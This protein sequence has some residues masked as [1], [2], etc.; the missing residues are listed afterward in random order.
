MASATATASSGRRRPKPRSGATRLERVG[1]PTAALPARRAD[2]RPEPPRPA[3]SGDRRPGAERK[4]ARPDPGADRRAHH[5]GPADQLRGRQ[6]GLAAASRS[7]PW[8]WGP[9]ARSCASWRCR[10]RSAPA[11]SPPTALVIAD[12]DVIADKVIERPLPPA[13]PRSGPLAWWGERREQADAA[14]VRPRPPRRAGGGGPGADRP[15]RLGRAPGRGGRAGGQ[16]VPADPER[17]AGAWGAHHRARRR[18]RHP[19]GPA[20]R[21]AALHPDRGGHERWPR[22]CCSTPWSRGPSCGLARAADRVRLSRARVHLPARP[23]GARGRGGR[24]R[25][26]AGEHDGRP[27]RAH[28]RHRALRR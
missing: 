9:P 22:P 12:T 18:G 4:P 28:G 25:P 2:P 14:R 8:T 1:A 11:C 27:E 13:R 17:G 26:G 16:R 10:A 5:P 21:A 3:G 23:V 19:V 15:P 6:G 24:P 7:P 20:P